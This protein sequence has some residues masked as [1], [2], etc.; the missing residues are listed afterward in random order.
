[1][2][3]SR[4]PSIVPGVILSL[5]A[6]CVV[7][8]SGS[9]VTKP[10]AAAPTATTKPINVSVADPADPN[11]AV[12]YDVP[13]L[14]DVMVDGRM[15]DWGNGGFRVDAM[16]DLGSGH[17]RS[18]ANFDPRFRLAWDDRG[19]LVL[20]QVDDDVTEE[21][22]EEDS[23]YHRDAIELFLATRRGGS[24]WVQ[25]VVAPG[26]DSRHP[27]LRYKMYD[28]RQKELQKTAAT[29]QL[30]RTRTQHGYILEAVLPW[31]N[32]GLT[33]RIGDEVAFQISLNDADGSMT[34]KAMWYPA[35]G[36]AWDSK[37]LYRLRLTQKPSPAI[38]AA[39]EG[40]YERFRRTRIGV[41]AAGDLAGHTAVVA[42]GGRV[43]ASGVLVADGRRASVELICPMPDPGKAY[44][45]LR[46]MVDGACLASVVLPDPQPQRRDAFDAAAVRFSRSVFVGSAFP[47]CDFE[48]PS[49]V[50]DLIGVYRLDTQFYAADFTPVKSAEKPGRYGAVVTITAADGTKSKRYVT[51][52][53]QP[54]NLRW[55]D[56]YL[57][58]Q[59]TLPQELGVDSRVVQRQAPTVIE[60]FKRCFTGMMSRSSDPAIVLA[61]LFETGPDAAPMTQ[62]NDVW[63]MDRHWWFGLRRRIGD[64]DPYQHVVRLPKDYEADPNA[65]HP[66]IIMLHGSNGWRPD[67]ANFQVT[68]ITK[69][70]DAHPDFPFILV[71]P[72]CRWREWWSPDDL[73]VLL[74]DISKRYRIDPDRVYLTGMSMGGY[75]TWAWAADQ[76]GR[77]AAIAPICGGGDP[78][79]VERLKDIPTWIFH[80]DLDMTVPVTVS[81]QMAAAITQAGGTPKLTIYPGVDHASWA[82]TYANPELYA[83][84]LEH[85]L[86]Q[87]A[88]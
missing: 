75:G 80:G 65:R 57:V 67:V 88:K 59:A 11:A 54:G 17:V 70:A 30:V 37:A 38:H 3:F 66:L 23:L 35:D 40:T 85:R 82:R 22:E 4:L 55:R 26:T 10:L 68:D 46:V 51:L 8:C 83:W 76:P 31:A 62:R 34:T 32:L 12:I 58:G 21:A 13:R 6:V 74:D 52:F 9:S 86:S 84:F 47:T 1:M 39:C 20:I 18:A 28:H 29:V 73:G 72:V 53:R 7:G 43:L 15:A 78:G 49:L 24:D 27:E 14:D 25:V 33:P 45:T 2:N 56:T 44:G 19:L 71:T 69:F 64:A 42:D 16:V 5:L 41:V 63:A 77:F 87:R 50:E 60:G 36:A 81:R 48:Q 61:G 79:D